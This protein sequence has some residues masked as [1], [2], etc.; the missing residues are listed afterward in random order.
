MKTLIVTGGSAGIGLQIARRL[1]VDGNEVVLVG[2]STD[3][4]TAAEL[5]LAADGLT[6]RTASLDVRDA[7]AVNDL[8]ENLPQ[9]DGVVNNAAGNFTARTA[10]MSL[11][12]FRA[13]VE[14]S[15][16]GTFNFSTAVARRLIADGRPGAMCNIITTYA[17]TGAPGVAHSAAAKAGMLA[18]T[19][20]VGR[21][22]GEHGIRV[23]AV[24]PGF[25]PTDSATA[26]ILSS[27]AAADRMLG[28]IPLARFGRTE[29]IADAVGFLMSDQAS[30]I[31]GSVLTVDGGRSLGVSMHDAARKDEPS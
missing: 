7:D 14:I 11:N 26:H 19:K 1:A 17:W 9:V 15:L 13:V 8:V 6:C 23:N 22:W 28:L 29:E 21:E 10:D 4:L 16:Y 3:R 20:S 5:S 31:T 12:G 25:V 24:A 30:Y 2:R 18:F 27:P